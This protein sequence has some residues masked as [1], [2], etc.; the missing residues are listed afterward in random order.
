VQDGGERTYR[1]SDLCC[2]E[3]APADPQQHY[4]VKMAVAG[5][6]KTLAQAVHRQAHSVHGNRPD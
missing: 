1:L 3:E 2:R 6:P 4:D 5:I